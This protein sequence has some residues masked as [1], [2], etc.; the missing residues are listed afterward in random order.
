[1]FEKRT[2]CKEVGK[3]GARLD[4]RSFVFEGCVTITLSSIL[5][6]R[7]SELREAAGERV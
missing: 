2:D 7:Y 4:K 3:K 1:M 6:T 5:S